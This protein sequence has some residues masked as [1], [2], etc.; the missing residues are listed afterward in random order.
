[1]SHSKCSFIDFRKNNNRKSFAVVSLPEKGFSLM[2]DNNRFIRAENVFDNMSSFRHYRPSSH[3]QASAAIANNSKPVTN[4][5][6]KKSNKKKLWKMFTFIVY[7]VSRRY[8]SFFFSDFRQN[9]K[10]TVSGVYHLFWQYCYYTYYHH[11]HYK[12]AHIPFS[13]WN[14]QKKN[15]IIF[16]CRRFHS[17][18]TW[19]IE[20]FVFGSVFIVWLRLAASFIW[21][22]SFM[23][24]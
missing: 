22:P 9:I 10:H 19:I 1:M 3:M 16:F 20:H 14:W 8:K 13:S 6:L 18:S 7:S 12:S 11:Y 17:C 24:R 21:L 23:N 4:K 5:R 15:S 2:D